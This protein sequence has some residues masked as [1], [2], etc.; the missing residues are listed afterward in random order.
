MLSVLEL[1]GF[2]GSSVAPAGL[3]RV[4]PSAALVVRAS[5]GFR[6]LCLSVAVSHSFR[7]GVSSLF[8]GRV[9]FDRAS[10]LGGSLAAC[11]ALALLRAFPSVICSSFTKVFTGIGYVFVGGALAGATVSRQA[12]LV[13]PS[14]R[15]RLN[16]ARISRYC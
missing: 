8:A 12:L 13:R 5:G 1:S 3:R 10:V 6:S 15:L 14:S 7:C 2:A 4:S 11:V 16:L 9:S